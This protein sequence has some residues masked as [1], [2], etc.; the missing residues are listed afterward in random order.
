MNRL[1]HKKMITVQET[2][3]MLGVSYPTALR[4]LQDREIPMIKIGKGRRMDYDKVLHEIE[5]DD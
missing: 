3:Y 4:W 2:A 1:G 5:K